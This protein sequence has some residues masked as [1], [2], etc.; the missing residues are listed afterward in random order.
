VK[1]YTKVEEPMDVRVLIPYTK[2][3]HTLQTVIDCLRA[4]YVQPE[5]VKVTKDDGY[6]RMLRDTWEEGK[7]FFVVEQDVVVWLGAIGVMQD[8]PEPWCS[9]PTVCHGRIIP[10]TF[11]CV[12]FSSLLIQQRPGFWDDI[13]TTWFHLDSG[14]A[15]KIGWPYIA[16]H[17]HEPIATHLNEVQWPDSISRRFTLERKVVWQS[18]EN[19]GKTVARVKY[20]IEGDGRK[21]E[22]VAA[23][24]VVQ[25]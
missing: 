23:A 18:M 16:P 5:L 24:E 13:P 10:T 9:L 15:D 20:R 8:C 4:Q 14:F 19:G 21:A 3:S 6:W 7:E 17:V 22:R 11:G 2:P 25:G 1:L 12:K